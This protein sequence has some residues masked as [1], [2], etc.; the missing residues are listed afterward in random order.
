MTEEKNEKPRKPVADNPDVS[1]HIGRR[2]KSIRKVLDITQRA[3]CD[4]IGVVS[5][6]YYSA[7]ETGKTKP[8]Y[9]FLHKL[10]MHYNVNPFYLLFGEE[11]KFLG[12]KPERD[13]EMQNYDF[14]VLKEPVREMLHYMVHCEPFKYAVLGFFSS[15]KHDNPEMLASHLKDAPPFK[16]QGD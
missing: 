16:K 11:P 2:I 8:G 6:S 14:G 9:D 15:F 1:M 4:K 7:I 5:S 10:G 3:F 12:D 13:L